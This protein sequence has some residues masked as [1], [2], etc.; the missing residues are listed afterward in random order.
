M[1]YYGEQKHWA[2]EIMTKNKMKQTASVIV[3]K[4]TQ[5]SVRKLLSQVVGGDVEVGPPAVFK[6]SAL[7][8]QFFQNTKGSAKVAVRADHGATEVRVVLE[9]RELVFG[10]PA[11]I[12]QSLTPAGEIKALNDMPGDAFLKLVVDSGFYA[13]VGPDEAVVVPGSFAIVTVAMQDTQGVKLACLGG[14]NRD[15]ETC[16]YLEWLVA[17]DEKQYEGPTGILLKYL[18]ESTTSGRL[19]GCAVKFHRTFG[20]PETPKRN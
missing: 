5:T 20:R 6:G 9:G 17:Q 4:G 13:S 8:P 18:K 19:V 10:F 11:H 14:P 16:H 2:K 7:D 15:K 12:L 1:D 3:R